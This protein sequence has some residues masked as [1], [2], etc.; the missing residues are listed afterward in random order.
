L[1]IDDYDEFHSEKEAGPWWKLELGSTYNISRV[2]VYNV[3]NS[4]RLAG[5]EVLLNYD[6]EEVFQ[7]ADDTDWNV[8]AMP[9]ENIIEL[10]EIITAD[11]I[12]VKLPDTKTEYLELE[13]VEVMGMGAFRGEVAPSNGNLRQQLS[14]FWNGN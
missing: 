7:Y 2:I 6:G 11:E 13:E 14:K 8:D 3:G 9:W 5:F 4:T 1:G 10:D 12:I